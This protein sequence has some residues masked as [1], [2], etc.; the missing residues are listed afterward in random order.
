VFR[1]MRE[2]WRLAGAMQRFEDCLRGDG[3]ADDACIR[4]DRDQLTFVITWGNRQAAGW[5]LQTAIE[6]LTDIR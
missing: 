4:F 3:T 2:A 1:R 5:P 6:R